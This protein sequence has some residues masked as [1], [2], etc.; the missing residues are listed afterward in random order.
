VV[1]DILAGAV[2][3]PAGAVGIPAGAADTR[4]R[5]VD[6]L[7]GA[8]AGSHRRLARDSTGAALTLSK[9]FLKRNNAQRI[10]H[11]GRHTGIQ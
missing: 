5:R 3:I 6:T 7:P 8:E 11:F 9:L 10:I 4:R 2:G 1:V